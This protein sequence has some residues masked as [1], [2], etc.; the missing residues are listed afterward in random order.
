MGNTLIACGGEVAERLH[1]H[2][3]KTLDPIAT[4]HNGDPAAVVKAALRRAWNLRFGREM[5]EPAFSRC[6]AAIATGLPWQ[7]A[8]W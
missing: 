7:S 3:A 5:P 4:I 1:D 8:L 2:L 6:V